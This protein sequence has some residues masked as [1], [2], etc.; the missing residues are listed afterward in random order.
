VLQEKK[1]KERKRKAKGP[2]LGLL[3]SIWER[4]AWGFHRHN[5]AVTLLG[6]HSAARMQEQDLQSPHR[7]HVALVGE[8]RC[9]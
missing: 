2:Y 8:E 1:K 5:L 6:K 3:L 7:N 9:G 4:W